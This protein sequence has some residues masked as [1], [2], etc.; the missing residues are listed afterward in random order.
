MD[1]C[2]D[3]GG[4]SPAS[5]RFQRHERCRRVSSLPEIVVSFRDTVLI[6]RTEYHLVEKEGNWWA[7]II[8]LFK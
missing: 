6:C 5:D 2:L 7:Q 8:N 3:N 1:D 4:T